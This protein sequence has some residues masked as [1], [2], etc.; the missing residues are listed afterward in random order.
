MPPIMRSKLFVPASRPELF[1]KACASAA[2]AVSFDLEDAVAP[3]RKDAA[4]AALADFLRH[5]PPGGTQGGKVVV[6]RVN[7]LGTPHFLP[8]LAAVALP[9]T[10][11]IN[12]PM[13]RDPAE[14][15]A[16]AEALE[17]AE[18]GNGVAEPIGLLCN[19]ETP[20][21]LRLAHAIAAAHPRVRGLQIGYAD[22][23]EPCGIDRDDAAAL[24]TL[25][26]TLRLAAAEAGVPAY[27]G[28][29]AAVD[30]PDAFRAEAE[31]ARRLG[32]A[33]KSCIH[34]SQIAAANAVFQ[35]TPAEIARARRIVEAGRERLAAG[36]GAFL[37]DG[38]MVDAPFI[39]GAEA[40]LALARR[41]GLPDAA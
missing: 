28:A 30:R 4:R 15:V 17:R 24:A 1:A 41:L 16:A 39:A 34:P 2:D 12:L 27:D 10:H 36:T 20:R 23:L 40:L 5:A 7:G 26:L 13:L 14:V 33:G 3:G 31:S 19:I 38:S 11:L 25:R 35:P 6:V 18:R 32:F 22:L 29:F 37:L 9:G 8:D 21:S